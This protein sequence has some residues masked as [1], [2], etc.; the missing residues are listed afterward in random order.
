ML[1]SIHYRLLTEHGGAAG[2]RDEGAFDAALARPQQILAYEPEADLARIAAAY[3]FGISRNH[4]FVD[5]N[6]RV[7]AL[8]TILFLERNGRIFTAS[9]AEV[10]ALFR[11]LAAGE[12][13]ESAFATWLRTHSRSRKRRES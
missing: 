13:E 4:P 10:A 5:G 2:L 1:L 12:M 3:G 11:L 7:A 6:K 9:E 8:A